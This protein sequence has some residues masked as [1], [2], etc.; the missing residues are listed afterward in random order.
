MPKKSNARTLFA[1]VD[2]SSL[3]K[4]L[5]KTLMETS[6]DKDRDLFDGE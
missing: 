3:D 1:S 2:L 5:V 4:C 6:L